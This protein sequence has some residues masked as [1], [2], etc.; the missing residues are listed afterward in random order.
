M[1]VFERPRSR[2][3]ADGTYAKGYEGDSARPRRGLNA[4]ASGGAVLHAY[5]Y[6][7]RSGRCSWTAAHTSGPRILSAAS[8]AEMGT[9]QTLRSSDPVPS[10][11]A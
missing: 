6:G 5:G 3:F 9:D 4:L 10:N 8:V 1:T 11:A 2:S 7:P